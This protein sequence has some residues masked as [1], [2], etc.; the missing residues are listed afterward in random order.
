MSRTVPLSLSA[1]LLLVGSAFA[2]DG[3]RPEAPKNFVIVTEGIVGGFV[4]AHVRRKT[5]IYENKGEYVVLVMTHA[6]RRAERKFVKGSLSKKAATALFAQLGAQGL[7][8]LPVE[9][10]VGIEDIYRKDTSLTVRTGDKQWR[11]GGPGGCSR[12]KS[13]IQPTAKQRTAFQML[14]AS[15]RKPADKQATEKSDRATFLTAERMLQAAARK[16]PKS[17]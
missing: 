9:S 14:L 7:W 2:Q 10:P 6:S 3:K 12:G 1:L 5:L 11:N 4:P 8:K 17:R 16:S 15:V 13:K